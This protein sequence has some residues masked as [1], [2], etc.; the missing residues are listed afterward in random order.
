MRLE[1][2][3]G[4]AKKSRKNSIWRQLLTVGGSKKTDREQE[5]VKAVN[6]LRR[7]TGKI[8]NFPHLFHL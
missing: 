8:V 4:T 1:T 6:H 7:Q 3:T 5:L 2:V